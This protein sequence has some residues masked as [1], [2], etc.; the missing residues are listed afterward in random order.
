MSVTGS[1]EPE[2]D[3][4][5]VVA[6]R[7]VVGKVVQTLTVTNAED[8]PVAVTAAGSYGTRTFA[9]LGAGKTA[10]ASF[11]TRL[12]AIPAGTITLTATAAVAGETVT[13]ETAAPYPAA[14]C[15]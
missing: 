11:T 2:L 5:A 13:V 15:G 7:C 4:T 6:A 9:S 8:V 14:T 3:V 1:T 12:A 10:S